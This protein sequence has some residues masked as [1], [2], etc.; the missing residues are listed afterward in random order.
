MK[1]KSVFV[2]LF[3]MLTLFLTISSALAED[4]PTIKIGVIYALTGPSA[5]T[6]VAHKSALEMG[7]DILNNLYPDIK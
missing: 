6:V 1:N 7:V 5:A 2:V 4:V 3:V